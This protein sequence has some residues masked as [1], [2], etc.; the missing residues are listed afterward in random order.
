MQPP[1]VPLAPL[2]PYEPPRQGL[3]CPKCRGVMRTYDRQGVH[4]EQ[5][6]TCRGIFLDFG[7]LEALIRLESQVR[8]APPMAPGNGPA[9]GDHHGQKPRRKGLAGLF[10]SS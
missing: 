1:S 2:P 3:Q 7:E 6:D 10:T 5:C 8:Q 4:I 9:W